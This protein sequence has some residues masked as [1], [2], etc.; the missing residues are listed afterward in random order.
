MGAGWPK[1]SCRRGRPHQPFFF[2]EN[3][4]KW[5]FMWYKNLDRCFS[6]FVTMH[7]FDK[8]T[9]CRMNTFL[10]A[11]L[12][13]HSMQCVTRLSLLGRV[14]PAELQCPWA[15]WIVNNNGR[16][17]TNLLQFDWVTAVTVWQMVDLWHPL[18]RAQYPEYFARRHQRKLEYIDRYEKKYGKPVE[19]IKALEEKYG[20]LDDKWQLVTAPST[21]C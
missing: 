11:S 19:E 21:H 4:S 3:L 1:I 7:A 5:S 13:W 17:V 12:C 8:K 16:S 6:H 14:L 18:E 10:I 15:V 20:P 2:S 9:D